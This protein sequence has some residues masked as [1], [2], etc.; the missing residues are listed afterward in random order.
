[1]QTRTCSSGGGSECGYDP[2]CGGPVDYDV[3]PYNGCPASCS[4]DGI[5]C[6]ATS[7]ILIDVSGNGFNLTGIDDPVSFDITG[8]ER[9]ISMSWTAAGSDD[10]FLVLDRNANGKI[11]DGSELFGNFTPQP[12]SRNRNGFIA[13]A[14]Y[15][16]AENGG[17][18]DGVMDQRDSVFSS[19]RLW[20]DVN[21]NGVSEPTELHTLPG[22]NIVALYLNYKESKRVDDQGNQFR[23]RAKV[24][25]AQHSEAGRWAWDVYFVSASQ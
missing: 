23:F 21:H 10:A 11:D 12:A 4:S 18:S 8:T 6:Y 1:V 13:L 22:L 17:D 2:G 7:P 5:C 16:K 19:L 25:D 15:D 24:D 9:P 20:Q 14:E 3:N